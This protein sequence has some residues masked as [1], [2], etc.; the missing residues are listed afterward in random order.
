MYYVVPTSHTS[1][2]TASPS[3]EPFFH[4]KVRLTTDRESHRKSG[5]FAG[6]QGKFYMKFVFFSS[7]VTIVTFFN[8]SLFVE[9]KE[10]KK[11]M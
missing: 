7:C 5:N 3:V 4:R 2:S 11:L 6:G 10:V 9:E 8:R 1:V